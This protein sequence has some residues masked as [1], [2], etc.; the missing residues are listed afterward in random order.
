MILRTLASP[1]T[2]ACAAIRVTNSALSTSSSF[3]GPHRARG[4]RTP[5]GAPRPSGTNVV[6]RA[7]DVP[8]L[9]L[10]DPVAYATM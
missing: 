9:T 8:A 3:P 1:I 5:G 10:R 4:Q 2:F 6:A 7:T